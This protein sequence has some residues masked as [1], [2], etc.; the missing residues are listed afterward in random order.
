M[1]RRYEADLAIWMAK[2]EALELKMRED[3]KAAKGVETM[4]TFE[5]LE[6]SMAA[7]NRRP[8]RWRPELG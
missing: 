7:W 6:I 2:C 5:S 1:I 3:A 8:F 4:D